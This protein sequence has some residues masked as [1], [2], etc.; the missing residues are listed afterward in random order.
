M[1]KPPCILLVHKAPCQLPLLRP[2]ALLLLAAPRP[3]PLLLLLLLLTLRTLALTR[4]RLFLC[5]TPSTLG[6]A[7]A[8][9]PLAAA[10][11]SMPQVMHALLVRHPAKPGWRAIPIATA[12]GTAAAAAAAATATSTASA[13]VSSSS[14]AYVTVVVCIPVG[15]PIMVRRSASGLEVQRIPTWLLTVPRIALRFLSVW[16]TSMVLGPPP[17]A[18]APSPIAPEQHKLRSS[19]PHWY[20]QPRSFL[21]SYTVAQLVICEVHTVHCTAR[22]HVCISRYTRV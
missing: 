18:R 17:A 12:A 20:P 13:V 1:H 8:I 15:L 6:L 5:P 16:S 4:V 10:R 14:T 11:T 19:S 2:P 22:F 9:T 21:H 7:I 3:L